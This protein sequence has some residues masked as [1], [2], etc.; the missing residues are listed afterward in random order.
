M[1][2]KSDR[3]S[4]FTDTEQTDKHSDSEGK[5][6]KFKHHDEVEELV[7]NVENI[8]DK[9]SDFDNEIRPI[10][11]SQNSLYVDKINSIDHRTVKKAKEGYESDMKYPFS[12]SENLKSRID[13]SRYSDGNTIKS[14]VSTFN[15]IDKE[16]LRTRNVY[17]DNEIKKAKY[18]EKRKFRENGDPLGVD[19]RRFY[20]SKL[21]NLERKLHNTRS[22]KHHKDNNNR[23]IRPVLPTA[24]EEQPLRP[25]KN[26]LDPFYM[27][28][29]ARFL[30]GF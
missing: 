15:D 5:I 13:K 18:P 26:Q 4:D 16:V 11:R 6:N 8:H 28:D 21:E 12:D 19:R 7:K 2:Y 25:S 30:H 29:R 20:Q 1:S 17:S 23:Q 27:P 9:Y 14:R 10:S 22:F 3:E 24:R